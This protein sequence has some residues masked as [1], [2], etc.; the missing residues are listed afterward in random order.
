[1]NMYICIYR[2]MHEYLSHPGEPGWERAFPEGSVL[3]GRPV[4]AADAVAALWLLPALE[5]AAAVCHRRRRHAGWL[6]LFPASG[7]GGRISKP[8]G[9]SCAGAYAVSAVD[10]FLY[11]I[12]TSS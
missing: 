4:D 1:M 7:L 5:A 9:L 3:A 10:M 12:V 8:T 11:F 6:G 2:Y